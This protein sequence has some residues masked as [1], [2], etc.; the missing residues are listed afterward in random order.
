MFVTDVPHLRLMRTRT[1]LPKDPK[2]PLKGNLAILCNIN[3]KHLTQYFNY[4]LAYH[5]SKYN[6]YFIDTLYRGK[7]G[8]HNYIH[9]KKP[10][11]IEH[12]KT[13]TQTDRRILP[14]KSIPSAKSKNLYF[15]LMYE[16]QIFFEHAVRLP[17]NKRV[18]AYLNKL[19]QMLT[20][21]RFN[22]YPSKFILIN[23]EE[24]LTY[25]RNSKQG[26]YSFNDPINLIFIAM[27]K[28]FDTFTQ[29][30]DIN[31]ILFTP[32]AYLR[33]NPSK[34][35]KN[36]YSVFR[37]ELIK[38]NNSFVFLDDDRSVEDRL[39]KE[40]LIDD[41]TKS[42]NFSR[43]FTGE[44]GETMD[45]A[46]K[47][48]AEELMEDDEEMKKEELE[49]ML[50]N[51]EK[52]IKQ[53]YTQLQDTKTGKSIASS[54]RDEELRQKQRDLQL[55]GMK[56]KDLETIDPQSIH[57][58]GTDVSSKIKSTNTNTHT[59]K[60]PDFEK[61]YNEVLYKKDLTDTFM[62]LNNKTI[63]V[64][65]K[66]IKV[67]DTSDEL[68]LK[69]TYTVTLE[70]S[71]R[72][73]HTVKVDMPL[74]IDDKFMYLGGNKKII[75][76]QLALKPIIKTGPDTVQICTNYKKMFV[77]RYGAKISPKIEKINKLFAS[78]EKFQG[79]SYLRGNHKA[80][81]IKY[82][83]SIEYDELSA[84][85]DRIVSGKLKLLFNQKE[86]QEELTKLNITPKSNELCIGFIGKEPVLLNLDTHLIG[87][88]DIVDLIVEHAPSNFV[89]RY[90]ETK[91]GKKFM[92]SRVKVMRREIPLVLLICFYEGIS[93]VLKKANIKH[94]FSD[95]RVRIDPEKEGIV[96]FS[97]GYLIY[98]KYPFENSLIMNAFSEIPTK[99]FSYVDLDDKEA[100][101]DIFDTLY[102]SRGLGGYLLNFYEFMIDPITEGV[103]R[104]LGYPTDL[105]DLIIYAN[106][107][108]V[109][110]Q[111]LK[112][113]EAEIYRTRSNEIVN[114][115]LYNAIAEAY[116]K[117][118][119]TS[120]N[121]NPIKISVPRDA[122]LKQILTAQTIEDYSI[123]NPIVELEKS[124]A[125]T[126]K[127][128]SGLN[129]SRAYTEEKRSYDKSMLGLI[130][131]S[132]SPD[133]NCGVVRQ[134]TLEP[135]IVGP[136][137]YMEIKKDKLD[138]LKDVNL[139][140]PAELLSPLG[141][142]RDNCIVTL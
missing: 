44:V 5:D 27:R 76:K 4:R 20:D 71:N 69:E 35:D 25:G 42:F 11:I 33:L 99:A 129:V 39:N 18:E 15:S 54:K 127:G 122:V 68:N 97:D 132:T 58:R 45:E 135:N 3:E 116:I 10:A 61:S 87:E 94:Y 102:G 120:N 12:Y 113:Y 96:E 110:N 130:A 56:L 84:H 9:N 75:V 46:I 138:E 111:C 131:V 23:V 62:A 90:N 78:N 30:G 57:L 133:A 91:V 74:F 136:R 59:I 28:Y 37:R 19:K 137:G 72:V 134:L 36:S 51:D 115:Y 126:P 52:L 81:N 2:Q 125:I 1:L 66:D 85:Y 88:K 64:F 93:T 109:D 114:I 117:Y 105:V 119:Q 43:G 128:P 60:Y 140:S 53:L 32:S 92:Y 13:I 7:I 34:C 67:K 83:S 50:N 26:K 80:E 55:K 14:V 139:F 48:R 104:D 142:T 100:Y 65:V 112:E 70:D 124:R 17:F 31:L 41:L 63:P 47:N 108:L 40:E 107:L 123:L 103:L 89:E 101:L 106:K 16:N 98:D 77:T 22:D 21:A 6:T 29:L 38:L 141:V 118:K 8:T 82:K 79:V 24:W 73:R 95:T 121:K 49:E 86:V